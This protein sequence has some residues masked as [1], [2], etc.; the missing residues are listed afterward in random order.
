LFIRC[1]VLGKIPLIKEDDILIP[2]LA[3]AYRRH[4]FPKGRGQF[5]PFGQLS[6]GQMGEIL[7]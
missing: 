5:L 6:E 7:K 1:I 4:G 3:P 2:S